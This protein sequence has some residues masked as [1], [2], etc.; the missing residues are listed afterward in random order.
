MA[1]MGQIAKTRDSF[2]NQG[3]SERLRL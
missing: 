2:A 1:G 3:L